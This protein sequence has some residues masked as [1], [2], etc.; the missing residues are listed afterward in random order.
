MSDSATT[1]KGTSQQKAYRIQA[2]FVKLGGEVHSLKDIAEAANL[3]EPTAH[4]WLQAGCINGIFEQVG[5]GMY[6]LGPGSARLGMRGM[7]RT[8]DLDATQ[9]VLQELNRATGGVAGYYALRGDARVCKAHAL[10]D[11][12]P[13][14]LNVDPLAMVN[15]GRSL[16]TGASGRVILAHLDSFMQESILAEPVPEGVGPGVIRSNEA[17]KATLD[18]IL[19]RGYAIGRQECMPGWDSVAA[20]VMWGA[21]I[22]G[23]I[24]LLVPADQMPEDPRLMVEA[25]LKAAAQLSLL[26]AAA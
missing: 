23:S 13:A 2:V 20:P 9:A 16:R 26:L 22:Q 17:L 24:L 4:S 11:H 8:P 15:V 3:K 6:R 21:M 12:T 5:R 18:D 1:G 19:A 7:S 10:G 14:S 25:T